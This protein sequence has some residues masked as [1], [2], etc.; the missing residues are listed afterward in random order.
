MSNIKYKVDQE[1]IKRIRRE[2]HRHPELGF[3][4][5]NTLAIVRRE[6]DA[7]GVWYTEKYGKSAIVAA[8]NSEKTNFTIGLRAD[9]DALPVLEMTDVPFK[10]EIPGVSHACGHDSHTAMAL[11][12]LKALQEIKDQLHCRFM[13]VFQP[14]EEGPESGAMPIV[15]DGIMD[16]IDIMTCL[17]VEVRLPA[18][19]IGICPGMCHAS[20]TPFKAEFHGKSCHGTAPHTGVNALAM[21]VKA[22]NGIMQ[23]QVVELD[24]R[25]GKVCSIGRLEAGNTGNVL[26]AYAVMQGTIRTYNDD[27]AKFIYKRVCEICNS[28]AEEVGGTVEMDNPSFYPIIYNDPKICDLFLKSAEKVVGKKNIV[29]MMTKMSSD[30]YAWYLTKKPG[31]IWRIGNKNPEKG[32]TCMG[33]SNDYQLDEDIFAIGTAGTVQFVIDNMDGVKGF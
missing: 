8:V 4:L 28:A 13:V 27:Y 31:F 2:I 10:S 33:H 7:L 30:D 29:P 6:L 12:A 21:A 18:G 16:Q 1:Y 17:H 32:I 5:P 23:M 9:M 24:P 19:T 26:P 25:E 22:Y 11:G 20:M 3:D 15:N 14:S